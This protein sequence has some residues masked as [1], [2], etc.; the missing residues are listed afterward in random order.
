MATFFSIANA[1]LSELGEDPIEFAQDAEGRIDP[2]TF[3]AF[4]QRIGPDADFDPTDLVVRTVSDIYP[5]VRDELLNAHPWTWLKTRSLLEEA[6]L[7][8]S[9]GGAPAPSVVETPEQF[10]DRM[11]LAESTRMAWPFDIRWHKPRPL[12]GNIRELHVG[13]PPRLITVGWDLV[14]RY[15][16]TDERPVI[17][18]YQGDTG[19][20]AYPALFV[21]AL[22][23]KLAARLAWPLTQDNESQGRFDRMA[24]AALENAQRVDSQSHPVSG[25][26]RFPAVSARYGGR[27]SR[28]RR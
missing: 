27:F 28:T 25:F 6:P 5:Q 16:Y 26:K 9:E 1:A 17:A 15:V 21:N 3:D 22:T 11:A 13:T 14:G 7:T 10:D 20:P 8:V 2:A 23:L 19:E 4:G 24:M 18:V 12:I